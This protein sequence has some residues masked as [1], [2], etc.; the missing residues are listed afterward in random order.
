MRATRQRLVNEKRSD[1]LEQIKKK[2]DV[3]MKLIDKSKTDR[4]HRLL[5]M[6]STLQTGDVIRKKMQN[7]F[8]RLEEDRL[9]I[10]RLIDTRSKK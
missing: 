7:H 9:E 6:N 8:D 5:K 4:A 3:S 1:T 10:E 2:N